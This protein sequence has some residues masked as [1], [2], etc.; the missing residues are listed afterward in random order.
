MNLA[1][2]R[3][4]EYLDV[5][6]ILALIWDLVEVDSLRPKNNLNWNSD[7]VSDL[8]LETYDKPGS[9]PDRG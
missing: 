5:R 6:A 2:N 9:G 4:G 3:F 1:Q 7:V 8:D